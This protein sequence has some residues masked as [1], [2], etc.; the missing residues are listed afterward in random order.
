VTIPV[1]WILTVFLSLAGVI[2]SLAALLWSTLRTRLEAQ[3]RIIDSLR[4][5]IVRLSKGCGL[6]NC[7]WRKR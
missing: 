2:G 5:D 7:L 6:E 1:D 4:A 3:D